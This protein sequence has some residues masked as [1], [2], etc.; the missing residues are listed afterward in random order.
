[1][2]RHAEAA[3]L[4]RFGE[5]RSREVS[6][7][8]AGF[9]AD[10]HQRAVP[11]ESCPKKS[12]KLIV[13]VVAPNESDR[14]HNLRFRSPGWRGKPRKVRPQLAHRLVT[15]FRGLRQQAANQH[16][17]PW[18]QFCAAVRLKPRRVAQDSRHGFH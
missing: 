8:D 14:R 7:A 5:Y 1:V 10:E 12:L 2:A 11:G 16:H 18:R 13:L 9:A 15:L 4:L 6:F 17:Q 3:E